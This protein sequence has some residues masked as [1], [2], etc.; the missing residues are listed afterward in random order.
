MQKQAVGAC[1]PQRVLVVAAAFLGAFC[2]AAWADDPR[3]AFDLSS[4]ERDPSAYVA[5]RYA[6]ATA[7][8]DLR[9]DLEAAGFSCS[10]PRGADAV[11]CGRAR[12]AQCSTLW[13]I[14]RARA[15]ELPQVER[16]R[17][18]RGVIQAAPRPRHSREAYRAAG[19][20]LLGGPDAQ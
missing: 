7:F 6:A 1:A 10:A 20:L 9:A 4:F 12:A 2:A 13:R 18:C 5:A 19:A 15:D 17:R 8:V 16:A 11:A 3:P 14:E